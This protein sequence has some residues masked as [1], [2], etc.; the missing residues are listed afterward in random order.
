ME[1]NKISTYLGFCIRAGKIVFGIDRIETLKKAYL[2]RADGELK[3][4]SF[5]IMLKASEKFST[6]VIVTEN[7]LLGELLHRPQVKAVAITD[8]QLALAIEKSMQGK[9]QFKLYSGGRNSIYGE[10]EL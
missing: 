7:N 1:M 2:L 10:E 5:K 8:E 3:E 6:K 9:P 4:N